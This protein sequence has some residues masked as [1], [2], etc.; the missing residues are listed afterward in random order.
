VSLTASAVLLAAAFAVMLG[1]IV[2]SSKRAEHFQAIDLPPTEER[3][4]QRVTL[5][6]AC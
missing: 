1:F 6:N 3:N 4:A 5:N 2:R